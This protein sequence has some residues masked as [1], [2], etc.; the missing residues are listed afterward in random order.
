MQKVKMIGPGSV[1]RTQPS[2]WLW[3]TLAVLTIGISAS[4]QVSPQLAIDLSA[5]T[6][7]TVLGATGSVYVIESNDR[8]DQSDGWASQAF[9]QVSSS[10]RVFVDATARAATSRFYRALLQRP[11]TNMVFIPPN[12]FTL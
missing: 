5:E 12:T 4:P 11:P 9:L 7:I 8:F 1:H 3:V 10:N 6:E 2:W